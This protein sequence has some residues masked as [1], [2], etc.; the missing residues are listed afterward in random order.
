M[1]QKFKTSVKRCSI[2]FGT[3]VP[4]GTSRPNQNWTDPVLKA[5]EAEAKSYEKTQ[6][7]LWTHQWDF[8]VTLGDQKLRLITWPDNIAKDIPTTYRGEIEYNQ[9]TLYRDAYD[10]EI[11]KTWEL[12]KPWDSEVEGEKLVDCPLDV[13]HTDNWREALDAP[14]SDPMWDSQ[15]DI[16]LYR[17]LF[18]SVAALNESE[19]A[20]NRNDA[21]L[22]RILRMDLRG[23]DKKRIAA[24]AAGAAAKPAAGCRQRRT[25]AAAGP[26][27]TIPVGTPPSTAT[28]NAGDEFGPEVE[29]AAAAAA[30]EGGRATGPAATPTPAAAARQ[31]R[32]SG[33]H[34]KTALSRYRK[35][36][37]DSRFLHGS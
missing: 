10:D 19:G 7:L 37:Q 17:I 24:A 26:A 18:Y 20:T 12:I 16:W 33:L 6:N 3:A 11:L 5:N 13:I 35:R 31:G 14:F 8:V 22:K 25:P 27:A 23:G 32:R 2:R 30:A 34:Q 36:I 15:E 4:K 21:P 9:R 1:V 29:Q 28:F